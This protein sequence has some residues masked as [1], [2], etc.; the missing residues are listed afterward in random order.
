MGWPWGAGQL[1]NSMWVKMISLKSN[2][3]FLLKPQ[4][5]KKK[6]HIYNQHQTRTKTER[7]RDQSKSKKMVGG[8]TTLHASLATQWRGHGELTLL[9]NFNG[10]YLDSL[11]S[12]QFHEANSW[13]GGK[14]G[15][16]FFSRETGA[17]GQCGPHR[18]RRGGCRQPVFAGL[19]PDIW[20]LAVRPE[21]RRWLLIFVCLLVGGCFCLDNFKIKSK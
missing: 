6:F 13:R 9:H 21:V 18:Q 5:K 20:P 2:Q 15:H 19:C 12:N 11:K 14:N 4:K 3:T 1:L 7:K 8:E 16:H 10:E 17:T